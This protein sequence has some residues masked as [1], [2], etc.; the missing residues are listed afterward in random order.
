MATYQ[1]KNQLSLQL[2]VNPVLK[3]FLAGS[4]SGTCSTLL[5]QPLD[6]VKT[7]IQQVGG[8]PSMVREFKKIIVSEKVSGLW[9]GVKPSLF[10][11]VP[12]VGVYFSCMH[13]V[14][15]TMFAGSPTPTQSLVVGAMARTLA[16][17]IMIPVTV[18]KIRCE[19][20]S[21]EYKGIVSALKSIRG[22]EGIKGL[23]KGLVPTLF[24]DVPFSGMYLMFYEKLKVYC[25]DMTP[26]QNIN[27]FSCG[28]G[29]GVLASLVTQPADVIKTRIQ[30]S[31]SATALAV[32]KQ[33]I[34]AEGP[35]GFL[36]GMVPRTLRRTLMASLAWTVYERA[37]KNMG[38]K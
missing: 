1:Q 33:I 36:R 28:I 32:I 5:F 21:M 26:Y 19:A 11:T 17:C 16:G 14:K 8:T 23:T 38:L 9:Q 12:G 31:P 7:R 25:K 24:R 13:T 18:V 30:L 6:L 20:G 29:A 2:S 37:V 4:F 27:H 10:R 3:S 15:T 35:S 22:T 34:R